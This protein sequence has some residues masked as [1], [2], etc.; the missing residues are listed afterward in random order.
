M[1][2]HNSVRAGT[3]LPSSPAEADLLVAP[4]Q[5]S[6]LDILLVGLLLAAALIYL[7]RSLW[8][9]RNACESC[10]SSKAGCATCQIGQYSFDT[11]TPLKKK[12]EAGD[13]HTSIRS[14]SLQDG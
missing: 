1:K 8:L 9:K 7:Y 12:S 11:E 6:I 5:G 14:E 4:V 10:A 2:E 13:E 3:L